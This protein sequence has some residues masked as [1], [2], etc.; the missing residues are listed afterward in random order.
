MCW[1]LT[2]RLVSRIFRWEPWIPEEL[3]QWNP[4]PDQRTVPQ[5]RSGLSAVTMTGY[6]HRNNKPNPNHLSTSTCSSFA[7]VSQQG[8]KCPSG[9]R[10]QGLMNKHDLNLLKKIE[11][12]RTL[13]DQNKA[14]FRT[15]DQVSKQTYDY[16]RDKLTLDSGQCVHR[17]KDLLSCRN[18]LLPLNAKQ[19]LDS[20]L[21]PFIVSPAR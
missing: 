7:P 1:R 13:L 11:K 9:C 20:F 3:D 21:D 19:S 18:K 4:A 2:W 6:G 5:Q 16:L 8:P 17:Q 10:V 14:K 12:I 15:A